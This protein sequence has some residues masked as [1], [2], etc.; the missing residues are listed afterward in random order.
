YDR[1]PQLYTLALPGEGTDESGVAVQT[2]LRL[3]M[4]CRLI[5]TVRPDLERLVPATLWHND[6]PLPILNRCAH[7]QMMEQI[8]SEKVIVI[9]NGQGGDE[10]TGGYFERLVG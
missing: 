4:P 1:M 9:L 6:E 5:D 2:A 3:G 10:C 7:W 8:A